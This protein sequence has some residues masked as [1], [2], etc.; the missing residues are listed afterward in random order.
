M[1]FEMYDAATPTDLHTK[2]SFSRPHAAVHL[3]SSQHG[4]ASDADMRRLRLYTR[5]QRY[6][7]DRTLTLAVLGQLVV[8][9]ILALVINIT[10]DQFKL[11]PMVMVCELVW[12]FLPIVGVVGVYVVLV[13]PV[14]LVRC[15]SLRDAYGIRNDLI[16]SIVVGGLCIIVTVIWETVLYHLAL[17]WSG[18][19]FTWL[20]AVS[21]HTVS[22]TVPLWSAWRH[23]RDLAH[24]MHGASSVGSHKLGRRAE[25]DAIMANPLEYR[26]F[27]DFAASCFCS[28]LTAFVDEYQTLKA[29]AVDSMVSGDMWSAE[30]NQ[31]EPGYLACMAGTVDAGVD[32]LTLAARAQAQTHT[33]GL[34]VRSPPTET[35]LEAARRAYPDL[36]INDSTVF[37]AAAMDK[38][39]TILGVFINS[40][41]WTAISLP[42]VLLLRIRDRLARSQLTLTILDEIREEILNM[43][44]LDV[45]TRYSRDH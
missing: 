4:T 11:S 37:P 42:S 31:L 7:S 39:V 34:H 43:L 40:A 41:S 38:L 16:V 5:L 24:R 2:G 25:F 15:W 28:E 44:Y 17:V 26:L 14:M 23:S 29:L 6:V 8:G 30:D 1:G 22:I 12:G 36:D 19:F 13:M 27:C 32:Y 45:F 20:C 33:H 9:L 3:T 35:I 21:L 10:D 18:W